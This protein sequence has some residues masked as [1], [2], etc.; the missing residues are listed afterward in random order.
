MSNTLEQLSR[1][2]QNATTMLG[3]IKKKT[4]RKMVGFFHPVVPEELLYAAGVQPIRLFP[5]FKDSI[6]ISDS[7]LPTYLCSSIRAVWDQVLKGRYPY[8][9]GMIIPRS[10]EAVTFLYQTWKRHNPYKFIDYLNV[11]WKQSE[12]TVSFFTKELERVKSNLEE[13]TRN[14]VTDSSLRDAIRLYNKNR[15]LLKT[16]YEFRKNQ[17]PP[18]SGAQA[19]DIVMSGFVIDKNEH[20][21]FLEELLAE[22]PQQ[23][24]P[25]AEVRILI[26]GG[27]VID[28]RLLEM[29]ESTQAKIVADDI[30]NGSRTF[31]HLVN[32]DVIDPLEAL[33]RRYIRVPCGFNTSIADRFEFVSEM[34]SEYKV[35]G[36]IFAIS[37]NCESEKFVYPELDEKI[38]DE[39][40]IPTLNIETDYLLGMAPLKTRIEAFVEILRS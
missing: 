22:L 27:C 13:F 16:V 25:Q 30:N 36:V 1:I 9:D 38:K 29:I 11:P 32:N 12:N 34:I 10:C 14:K 23:Q 20:N 2:A 7:Y 33:A 28:R 19:Y 8:L 21:K 5:Y 39:L 37:K 35:D 4:G 26:S 6:T 31:W 24:K 3:D 18:I 17:P 15:E 40:R